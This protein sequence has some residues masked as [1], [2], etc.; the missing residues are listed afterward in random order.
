MNKVDFDHFVDNYN[1]L[2]CEQTRFFSSDESYFAR[3]KVGIA[4]RLVA[5]APERILEYG[6]GIGRNIPF[7]REA[8]AGAQV[9]GSDVSARSVEFARVANP[10]VQFWTEGDAKGE[11]ETFDLIFVA[12]VF[13]HVPPPERK[14]TAE[15]LAARLRR[16]GTIVVFEHNPYNP[17]TRK[18]VSECP[19]DKGVVL[20]PPHELRGCLANAGLGSFK[21]GYSLFFPPS[22]KVL[23]HLE[24]MLGWLPLGGQYWVCA[25]KQ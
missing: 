8:F 4:R 17:V 11:H 23:A 18:I 15:L 22:L 2:L 6:C 9:M 14:G 12:G 19:Y 3:Y 1:E 10:G 7:L 24:P 21:Q 25:A 20:L 5:H 13:H 16:G